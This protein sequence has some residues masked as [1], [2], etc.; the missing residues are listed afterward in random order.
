MAPLPITHS[1][2]PRIAISAT[3]STASAEKT[4]ILTIRFL[5][6]LTA[7]F[8]SRARAVRAGCGDL[9]GF[10]ELEHAEAGDLIE[11]LERM[12][13]DEIKW[14]IEEVIGPLAKMIA[15]AAAGGRLR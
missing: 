14:W 9:T 8:Y 1:V 11:R 3:I 7:A 2:S 6:W 5:R 15:Q 10:D 13:G 12:K 4:A